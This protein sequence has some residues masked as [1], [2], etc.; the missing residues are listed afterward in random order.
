MLTG[1]DIFGTKCAVIAGD[2]KAAKM[3]VVKESIQPSIGICTGAF[4]IRLL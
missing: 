1:I 4:K 2:E 3:R